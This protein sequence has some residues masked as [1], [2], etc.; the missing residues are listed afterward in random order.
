MKTIQTDQPRLELSDLHSSRSPVDRSSVIATTQSVS[1]LRRRLYLLSAG[2]FFVLAIR[3]IK[4]SAHHL[5]TII[6]DVLDL[7]K[8]EAGKMTLELRRVF[9]VQLIAEVLSSLEPQALRS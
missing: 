5:L 7:S 1:G 3:T 2:G 4:S 8:I 9:P 6:N